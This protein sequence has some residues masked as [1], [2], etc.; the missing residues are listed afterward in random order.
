MLILIKEF[1][2]APVHPPP[3]GCHP[4]FFR[5]F[6]GLIFLGFRMVLGFLFRMMLGFFF[7]SL[8]FF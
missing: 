4:W 3:S 5:F 8:G 1:D 2:L 6:G 7:A